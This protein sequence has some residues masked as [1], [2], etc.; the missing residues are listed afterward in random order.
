MSLV[1]PAL[2]GWLQGRDCV[3]PVLYNGQFLLAA[4]GGSLSSRI[5]G[6]LFL[7]REE[8]LLGLHPDWL[9]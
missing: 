5:I 8:I 3:F 9:G 2:P 6:R 4:G 7:L 1:S